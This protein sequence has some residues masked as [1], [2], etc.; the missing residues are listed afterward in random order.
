V[1][2]PDT[3]AAPRALAL[4]EVAR[5]V[6]D[7]LEPE[8]VRRGVTLRVVAPAVDTTVLADPVA[9]EQ[10]VHNLV[11][12]GLQALEQ[13]PEGERELEIDVGRGE[14][15]SAV[16]VVRDSGPGIA[17]EAMARIFEPFFTTRSGGLGLGLSL[18]ETLAAGMGGALAGGNRVPRGAEFRLTLPLA[19]A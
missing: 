16:L 9:V 6:A 10:I 3:A 5:N 19:A 11:M 12:N 1:Q 17:P 2:R 18:C 7:L 8:C 15:G 13:V 14:D 4:A